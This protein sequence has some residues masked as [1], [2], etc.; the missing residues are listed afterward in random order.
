MDVEQRQP[1]AGEETGAVPAG[2]P[3]DT[4]VVVAAEREGEQR[5]ILALAGIAGPLVFVLV[6][7]VLGFLRAGYDQSAQMISQLAELG[8]WTAPYQTA[9]FILIG[10]LTLVFALALQRGAGRGSAVGP[11]L[12][13]FVGVAL[14][15]VA[16]LPCD[17][18]C[19]AVTTRGEL[20]E[21]VS[22][23]AFIAFVLG[24]VFMARR[25]GRSPG[26]RGYA[27]YTWVTAVVAFVL[28][29]VFSVVV[30]DAALPSLAPYAGLLQR[31]FVLSL[32][33]WM[34]VMG[35]RL[36]RRAGTSLQV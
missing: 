35:L 24:L 26:W 33:Q 28:L 3:P 2:A 32:L 19:E 27:V 4:P 16:A 22:G 23:L 15:G 29:V 25:L 9:N 6:F 8:A 10:V 14:A 20:H 5:N 7:T 21:T 36:Y 11:L 31:L 1:T 30:S 34:G 18:G 12:I 13:A 17:P